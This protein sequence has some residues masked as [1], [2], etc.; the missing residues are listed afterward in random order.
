MDNT[1]KLTIAITIIVIG[2]FVFLGIITLTP[3]ELISDKT[4]KNILHHQQ[5]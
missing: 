2:F 3:S 4:E 1:K 5:D